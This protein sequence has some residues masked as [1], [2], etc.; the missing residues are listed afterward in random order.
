MKP[1]NFPGRVQNR[2]IRAAARAGLKDLPREVGTD[3]RFRRANR[4]AAP[5]KLMGPRV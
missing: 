4:V 2:R 5:L 3:I 1:R